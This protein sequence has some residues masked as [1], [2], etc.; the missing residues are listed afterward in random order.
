MT[1]KRSARAWSCVASTFPQRTPVSRSSAATWMG[2]PAEQAQYQPH[3]GERA[4]RKDLLE[5]GLEATTVPTPW[6]IELQEPGPSCEL[7][8]E[9]LE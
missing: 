5:N 9:I 2:A 3:S 8:V 6:C 4:G 7:V 1:P